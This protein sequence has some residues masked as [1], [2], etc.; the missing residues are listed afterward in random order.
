M[1]FVKAYRLLIITAVLASFTLASLISETAECAMI[2]SQ[3]ILLDGK[4]SVREID[5]EKIRR[6]LENKIVAEKLKGYGLSKEEVM[7]KIDKMSDGQIHQ[8]ATL[9]DKIPT[10]GDAGLAVAL[11]IIILVF[12]MLMLIIIS[13]RPWRPRRRVIY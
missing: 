2:G 3:L 11:L 8:I 1:N 9:S 6:A 10:G 4:T 12:L 13:T 5:I 7:A